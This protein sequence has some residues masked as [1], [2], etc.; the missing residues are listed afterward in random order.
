MER[1]ECSSR[2]PTRTRETPSSGCSELSKMSVL[3]ARLHEHSKRLTYL[4]RW[5]GM[6]IGHILARNG[7]TEDDLHY[8]PGAALQRHSTAPWPSSTQVACRAIRFFGV[9]KTHRAEKPFFQRVADLGTSPLGR[10]IR[11]DSRPSNVRFRLLSPE[12]CRSASGQIRSFG[13]GWRSE[14]RAKELPATRL[15]LC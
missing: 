11:L 12:T 3:L 4:R 6:L 10:T 5:V 2:E 13:C 8:S 14:P 1:Q 9:E 7:T 15:L